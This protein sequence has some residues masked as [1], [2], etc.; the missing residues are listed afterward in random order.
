MR[1]EQIPPFKSHLQAVG[2]S[3]AF[4][5]GHF[6]GRVSHRFTLQQQV[7]T[8]AFLFHF[9]QPA[10]PYRGNLY[11]SPSATNPPP[12]WCMAGS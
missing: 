4:L 9:H 8:T 11:P 5:P 7:T 10:I 6:V 2:I 1:F 12:K 3:L